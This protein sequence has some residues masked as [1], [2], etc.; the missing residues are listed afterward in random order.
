[1]AGSLS[2][3]GQSAGFFAADDTNERLNA[4]FHAIRYL[5]ETSP[6]DFRRF[7][8]DTVAAAKNLRRLDA[9]TS[10]ERAK[11]MA[12][13]LSGA[14]IDPEATRATRELEHRDVDKCERFRSELFYM[15]QVDPEAF[16][17]IAGVI[18]R[19]AREVRGKG[20]DAVSFYMAVLRAR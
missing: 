18:T 13:R 12:L 3:R 17:L 1:M 2:G 7:Y 6:N 5:E 20:T 14:P 8:A 9:E 15:S 4:A 19:T 10:Q 11:R 16:Y